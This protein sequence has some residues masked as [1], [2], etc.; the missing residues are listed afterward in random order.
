MRTAIFLRS[1]AA[2]LKWVPYA[3][4][5][6][7]KFVSG[8]EEIII[9]VPRED[10]SKFKA[11][12]LTREKVVQSIVNTEE[13]DPYCGQQLDKLLADYYTSADMILYWDSDV[14][15]TRPFSPSD[16]LIDGK[17]RCLITPFDKLVNADGSPAV[18]WKPIVE[19]AL[20]HPVTH[21]AMR[22]H[23][24]M[25]TRQALE[26]LRSYMEKLH[27]VLLSTYVA[28]QPY[29]AFSEFNILNNWAFHHRPDLFSWWDTEKQGVPEPFARQ[30]WSYSGLTDS[31]RSEMEKALA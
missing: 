2:D 7:H 26:G 13:M 20:G 17:P 31:E 16:L 18:P 8:V 5:S 4:R 6:I 15:A 22:A 29:R 27:R 11:L 24:F 19:K 25:A 9:S 3:L 21:E 30:F 23:P 14:I 10:L 12:D 28:S 1:Y